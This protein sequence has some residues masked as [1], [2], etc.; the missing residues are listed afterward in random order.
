MLPLAEITL[1]AVASL[2]GKNYEYANKRAHVFWIK[3]RQCRVFSGVVAYTMAVFPLIATCAFVITNQLDMWKGI[4]MLLVGTSGI[5]TAIFSLVYDNNKFN[6]EG[7]KDA[8]L[9][10]SVWPDPC[11]RPPRKLTRGRAQALIARLPTAANGFNPVQ[12]PG[13]QR[14]RRTRPLPVLQ[15]MHQARLYA[16]ATVVAQ[17]GAGDTRGQSERRAHQ[18][19]RAEAQA[20]SKDLHRAGRRAQALVQSRERTRA[21]IP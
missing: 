2:G 10:R 14:M 19:E 15:S 5:V 13:R 20:A 8:K 9:K 18:Q 3:A 4:V 7:A 1:W 12:I 6:T 11:K 16:A 17:V 21:V